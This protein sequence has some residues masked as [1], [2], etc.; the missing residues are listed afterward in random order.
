M[1][2]VYDFKTNLIFTGGHDGEI[3]AWHFE[4]GFS[5]YKLSDKD[6]T[7]VSADYVNDSKSVDNLVIMQKERILMSGT[8]DGKIRFW[9]LDDL[10]G[11]SP[12]LYTFKVFNLHFEMSIKEN[13][14]RSDKPAE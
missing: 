13:G 2:C 5:K 4:T 11:N 7:C 9:N 10:G 3:R 8:C 14:D 6:P 1:S 12:L